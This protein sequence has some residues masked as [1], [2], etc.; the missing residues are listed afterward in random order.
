MGS[1]L[2]MYLGLCTMESHCPQGLC[3]APIEQVVPLTLERYSGSISAGHRLGVSVPSSLR[4][5]S[6]SCDREGSFY[7]TQS[8]A[9]M[10]YFKD[11]AMREEV[12]VPGCHSDTAWRAEIITGGPCVSMDCQQVEHTSFLLQVPSARDSVCLED[13][14]G[15]VHLGM[16][17]SSLADLQPLE[18]G[19]LDSL[20]CSVFNQIKTLCGAAIIPWQLTL[21]WI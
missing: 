3:L 11:N 16:G 18:E 5:G 20:N 10:V 14:M 15:A 2:P 6:P 9:Y 4:S 7:P 1:S 21:C 17:L 8:N 12:N 19:A 13:F